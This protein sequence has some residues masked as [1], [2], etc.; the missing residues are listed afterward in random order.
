[1]KWPR[2]KPE[3]QTLRFSWTLNEPGKVLVHLSDV[4]GTETQ[5]PFELL[6]D[7]VIDELPNVV[8]VEPG[9]FALATPKAV[10]GLS[11]YASD[12]LGL[13]GVELVKALVGFRDRAESMG[14]YSEEIRLDF[15]R[16]LDLGQLGVQAG[17]TLEF[18]VEAVDSNPYGLHSAVS[19]VARIQ[20]VSEQEYAEML[21]AKV[22]SNEFMER[23]RRV[24]EAR[25]KLK[26]AADALEA[27]LKDESLSEEEKQKALEA[28]QKQLKQTE[29]IYRDLAKDFPVYEA[30]ESLQQE[31]Q[32]S[33]DAM[34]ALG[35]QLK[36]AKAGGAACQA[37][38]GNLQDKLNDQNNAVEQEIRSAEEI[39]QISQI[40]ELGIMYQKLLFEQEAV[41]RRL[42]RYADPSQIDNASMFRQ[43][44]RKEKQIHGAMVELRDTLLERANALPDELKK[45]RMTTRSFAESIDAVEVLG[46]LDDAKKGA[47]N[48]DG[49]R[50]VQHAR[51]ALER[52]KEL[53]SNCQGSF[54]NLARCEPKFSVQNPKAMRTIQQMMKSWRPGPGGLG[55]MGNLGGGGSDDDG[56]SMQGASPLNVPIFGPDR[57]RFSSPKTTGGSGNAGSG[58]VGNTLVDQDAREKME[59]KSVVDMERQTI[60][61]ER[62]PEKYRD[63]I[64]RFFSHEEER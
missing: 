31:L 61:F 33:A 63:A 38:L 44:A 47:Q 64:K 54:G 23:F 6:Q 41:V 21:R 24:R 48:Q 57:K 2:R 17:Q 27:A 26:Q 53:L 29:A 14:P 1:M 37:A 50:L 13:R 28:L 34:Q 36:G 32:K 59:S 42:N 7:V 25:Q 9:A 16:E 18:Y 3:T 40:M 4:R 60:Q 43:L 19:D 49:A 22:R 8:L 39:A 20:I 51:V 62:L 56:Y 10:L 12:D 46:Q 58:S 30:E 35:Q 11:G 15:D 5:H 55:G 45:L 52:M